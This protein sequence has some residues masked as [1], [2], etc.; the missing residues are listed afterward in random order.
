MVDK[1]YLLMTIHADNISCFCSVWTNQVNN[2]CCMYS[3][4]EIG[5]DGVPGWHLLSNSAW[6]N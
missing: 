4:G 3:I 5:H 1:F 6:T 2:K